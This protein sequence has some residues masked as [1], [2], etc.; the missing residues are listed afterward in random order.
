MKF[1]QVT[2]RI[3]EALGPIDWSYDFHGHDWEHG[4]CLNPESVR[5]AIDRL[6]Y[7]EAN[8]E[9]LEITTYGGWPR[10]GWGGVITL[11]MYD[12]WPEWCPTPSACRQER[13][14]GGVVW[15]P[16]YSITNWRD[17]RTGQMG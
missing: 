16:W 15:E 4:G 9:F 5:K 14:L 17:I 3:G 11:A 13:V 10:C 12:G 8:S 1:R 2:E 7:I 6:R